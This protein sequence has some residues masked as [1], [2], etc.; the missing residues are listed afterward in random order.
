MEE[1]RRG[2]GD[3]GGVGGSEVDCVVILAWW[4]HQ[5]M[6]GIPKGYKI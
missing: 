1:E 2:E 5:A 4:R 6:P 3:G